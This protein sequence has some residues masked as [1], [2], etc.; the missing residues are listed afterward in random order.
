MDGR[1]RVILKSGA[2]FEFD[3]VDPAVRKDWRGHLG[4]LPHGLAKN[5]LQRAVGC[6][7]RRF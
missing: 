3:A 1:V 4:K 6:E 7:R 2:T 5:P